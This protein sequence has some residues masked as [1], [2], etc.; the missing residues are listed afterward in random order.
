MDILSAIESVLGYDVDW[1]LTF[2]GIAAIGIP[3]TLS[4]TWW[5][6]R[7]RSM[8]EMIDRLY[9]LCHTLQGHMLH[10]WRLSHLFCI[11]GS[12]YAE[13]VEKIATDA[14]TKADRSKLIV[15]ERQFAIHIFVVF[16]QAYYQR[17]AS[18]YFHGGRRKFLDSM[19]EYFADRLLVNPRL[20]AFLNSD[21][22]GTTL[23]LEPAAREYLLKRMKTTDIEP[24]TQ[25]PFGSP[26]AIPNT[27]NALAWRRA[28]AA[29]DNA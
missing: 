28:P 14:S 18:R 17:T 1:D 19:L 13:A 23:H 3:F 27:P 4:M 20:L 15:E 10:E 29:A 16:E 21:I 5:T 8:F 22:A 11:G 2:K 9:S 6:H 7:Q 24:D 25:G 26:V 12:A